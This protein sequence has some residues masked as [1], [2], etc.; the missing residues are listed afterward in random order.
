V[1]KLQV[2]LEGSVVTNGTINPDQSDSEGNVEQFVGDR[3]F[4][5][6]II[7]L[8]F[9]SFAALMLRG[10]ETYRWVAAHLPLL[11]PLAVTILSILT[12]ASGIQ[13]IESVLKMSN[14]IAIGIISF[15]FWAIS[16]SRTER[17]GRIFVNPDTMID[18]EFVI[19]LLLSGLIIAVG[20]VVLNYYG[21]STQRAKLRWLFVGFIASILVY[22]APFGILEPAHSA[23]E[24]QQYSVLIPYQDP[25]LTR[26]A[27]R[28]LKERRLVRFEGYV[29]G[30]TSDDARKRAIE[31]FLSSADPDQVMGHVG[32][33]V[34]I[35]TQEVFVAKK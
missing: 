2:N 20:C 1:F 32:D 16:A 11:L 21:F 34:V 29:E 10:I 27:P 26:I 18:G 3:R 23:N 35:R 24:L 19:P 25:S 33:K 8:V 15:D 13:N 12:R 31:R 9:V 28:F 17:T 14:D 7:A 5:I 22:V 4:Y 30:T 6:L